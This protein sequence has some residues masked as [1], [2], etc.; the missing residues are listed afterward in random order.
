VDTVTTTPPPPPHA[1]QPQAVG[2]WAEAVAPA[3]PLILAGGELGLRGECLSR[4][5]EGLVLRGEG[6]R[7][8]GEGLGR[9]GDTLGR[10]CRLVSQK[11]LNI[12]ACLIRAAAAVKHTY[13]EIR[14]L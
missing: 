11:G 2:E 12:A 7:R 4:R 1:A 5:G 14:T 13:L 6:L 9:R 8:R 10:R 3:L